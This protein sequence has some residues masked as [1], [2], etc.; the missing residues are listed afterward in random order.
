MA[1]LD[2]ISRVLRGSKQLRDA[3]GRLDEVNAMLTKLIRAH[4]RVVPGPGPGP[5][6][7]PAERAPLNARSA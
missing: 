5:G 6:P 2:V 7:G 4:S 1:I 3:K